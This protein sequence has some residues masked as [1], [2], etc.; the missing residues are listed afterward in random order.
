MEG[1]WP[2]QSVRI[3]SRVMAVIPRCPILRHFELVCKLVT[4]CDGA[5]RYC[6]D[7]IILKG[8][9]HSHSVPVDRGP[10]V[11]KLINDGDFDL[12]SPASLNEGARVGAVEGFATVA[13]LIAISVDGMFVNSKRILGS[14][15][16]GQSRATAVPKSTRLARDADWGE[17]VIVSEDVIHTAEGV[18]GIIKVVEP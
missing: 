3:L 6:V 15:S 17:V 5:L 1:K 11:V 13:T 12:V 9:Q 18:L 10:I 8:I 4:R 2:R 7:T 14:K 16:L